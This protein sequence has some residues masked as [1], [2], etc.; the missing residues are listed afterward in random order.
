MTWKK[1]VQQEILRNAKRI[2]S[3]LDK[4]AKDDSLAKYHSK[5]LGDSIKGLKTV[6]K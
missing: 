4:N 6:W 5:E 2:K 1:Q 3:I